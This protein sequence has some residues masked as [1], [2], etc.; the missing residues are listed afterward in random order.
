MRVLRRAGF[1]AFIVV[2]LAGCSGA[3]P[4]A[5]T[6][7]GA[8]A[9]SA[10]PAASASAAA[11]CADAT[12][13][14]TVEV[15]I[16]NFAF[17]PATAQAKVGDVVEWTNNDSAPHSAVIDGASCATETLAGG[18]SGALVF[19]EPGTYNYVCGIHAQMK[20]TVEVS[21]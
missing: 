21:G 9:S 14:A 20:G 16:A 3:Q 15:G 1:G 13:A 11:A 5:S 10:A 12:E 17:D 4:A 7:G 2:A 6:P 18:Q 8:A 19:N